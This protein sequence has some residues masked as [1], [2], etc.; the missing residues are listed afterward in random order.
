MVWTEGTETNAPKQLDIRI[1]GISSKEYPDI[2]LY[3]VITG[4][5][6]E[7]AGSLS[8]QL[9]TF[10]IDAMDVK[11]KSTIMPFQLRKQPIDYTI[12]FSN[13]GIMEGEPLDF[14][15]NGI[16]QFIEEMEDADTLSLYT[17]GDEAV[18]IFEQQT[19][20]DIDV[21]LISSLDISSSQPRLYDSIMNVARKAERRTEAKG[22]SGTLA[23]QG[24]TRKVLIVVSDGRDQNSRFSKDQLKEVLSETGI[25]LYAIGMRVLNDQSLSNLDDL[26]EF[27]GGSYWYAPKVS[28]IPA[29]LK[30]LR[31]L[32]TNPYVI[33]LR[34]RDVKA[35]DLSHTLELS[36]ESSDYAGKGSKTFIAVK[37]PVPRWVKWVIAGAVLLFIIALVVLALLKRHLDRKKLGITKRRCPECH[38]RQKDSWDSCPFCK[39]LPDIKKKKKKKAK[40]VKLSCR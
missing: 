25:P 34:V 39:Y 23:I 17:V 16:F 28:E 12:L 24:A 26:A 30:G 27:T 31:N 20:A 13:N 35:D 22:L 7:I 2:R 29:A 9:F 8:P 6:R 37:V 19:K 40:K 1:D 36:V 5:K 21:S 18:K 15:K 14:Q 32:I 3:A 4:D 33:D 38:H 11:V 10:K